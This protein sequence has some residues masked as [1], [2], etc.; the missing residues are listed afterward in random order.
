MGFWEVSGFELGVWARGAW[1]VRFNSTFRG[2]DSLLLLPFGE[3]LLASSGPGRTRP[4]TLMVVFAYRKPLAVAA[5]VLNFMEPLQ[6][7]Q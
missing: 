5:L 3:N 4:D 1:A 6:T 2:Y 7:L